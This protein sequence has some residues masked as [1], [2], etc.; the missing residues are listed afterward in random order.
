MS[1][2][3][4]ELLIK[5]CKEFPKLQPQD[6]FKYIFHS[7]F[8]CDHLVSDKN[9][10]LEYIKREY[11]TVPKDASSLTEAL[12]G[13]YARV[14]LSWLNNGLR[15][16]TLG[17][18]FCFSARKEPDGQK[19]LREML[20]IARNLSD[21]GKLPFD[22]GVF[23]KSLDE[24]IDNGNPSLHHSDIFR[25][26][27]RPS[28]RVIANKYASFLR[29]FS[30][31]DKLSYKESVVVAIEGGSASGKTT[32]S[33]I[34]KQV[35]DCNVFH[36]DDF[37]LRPEQRTKERLAEIGGNVDRERFYEE[38]LCPLFK[39]EKVNYRPFDCTS[40]T[41]GESVT[42]MPKR[43]NIIEGVYSTHPAFSRYFDMAVFLDIDPECQKER[44]LCRN[45]EK[46]AKRFFDEWIPLEN[47]YFSETDIKTRSDLIFD[48]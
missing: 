1:E 9:T 47:K 26:E 35:Y 23:N 14:H 27:Y 38:V 16:E 32:L 43:I 30:E 25:R 3:T 8:G 12:D 37:F 18:I 19:K 7:A 31:I 29:L 39:N 33:G 17:K 5:H 36:M 20:E 10:A 45:G 34:L 13:N 46:L 21:E 24:W 4:K 48:V 44:V 40:Q 41:I 15:P 42:V 22:D 11:E 28:Y 2:N 6:L